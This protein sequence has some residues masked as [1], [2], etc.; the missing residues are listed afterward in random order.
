VIA[1]RA[2]RLTGITIAGIVGGL[3]AAALTVVVVLALVAYLAADSAGEHARKAVSASFA[4]GEV[5]GCREAREESDSRIYRCTITTTV[6]TR[7]FLFVVFKN[8][9]YG[10]APY[11]APSYI[12]DRPCNFPS[13]G[14]L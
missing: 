6:C 8:E 7:S 14:P 5:S 3:A 13:D 12:F 11:E 9:M 2:L 1:V 10:T 4:T